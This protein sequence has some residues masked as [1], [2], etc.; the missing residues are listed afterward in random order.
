MKVYCMMRQHEASM[1]MECQSPA[2]CCDLLCS[3]R[4][5]MRLAWTLQARLLAE[6]PRGGENG[7]LSIREPSAAEAA[8]AGS[9]GATGVEVETDEDFARQMQAKFDAQEARRGWDT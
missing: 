2:A 6:A 5:R 7:A 8:E 4:G 9:N 1:K 3:D